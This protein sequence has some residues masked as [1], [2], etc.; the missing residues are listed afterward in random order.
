MILGAD[1]RK[2]QKHS[3]VAHSENVD[4]EHRLGSVRSAK[5]VTFGSV[6]MIVSA[7]SSTEVKRNIRAGQKA[8]S[9][10]KNV[11]L[12][13]GVKLDVAKGVPLFSVDLD[14][15]ELL[16]RKLNGKRERGFIRNG[17]F[18]VCQ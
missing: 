16:V 6:T 10:A 11:F 2:R 13:P 3:R 12:T 9:R 7:P 1:K 4:V 17:Q 5:T 8:L 18:E 15:P 14:N